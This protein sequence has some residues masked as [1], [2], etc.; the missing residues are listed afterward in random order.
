MDA[1]APRRFGLIAAQSASVM[2]VGLVVLAS[3]AR[4]DGPSPRTMKPQDMKPQEVDLWQRDKLSGDW[5][6]ARTELSKRGIDI[7]FNYMG[8]TLG[9]LGGIRQGV[10]YEHRFELSVDADLEKFLG[11]NG[12]SAHTSFYQIG[13]AHGTPAADYTGS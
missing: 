10:S 12:A 3:P 8:E 13:H 9:M 7:T 4:A 5:G 6:G 1:D 11:W 2:L